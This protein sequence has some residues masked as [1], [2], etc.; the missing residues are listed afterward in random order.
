MKLGIFYEIQ[1][2]SPLKHPERDRQVFHDA[3]NPVVAPEEPGDPD[4]CIRQIAGLQKGANLDRFLCMSQFWPIPHQKTMPAID[5]CGNYLLPISAKLSKAK[6][7]G[8]SL[9]V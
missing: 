2:A 6:S 8:F 7:P 9:Q 4:T 1:V 5:L 3:L